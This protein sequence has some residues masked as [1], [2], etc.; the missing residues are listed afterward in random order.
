MWLLGTRTRNKRLKV[1]LFMH[2]Q[3]RSLLMRSPGE[4]ASAQNHIPCQRSQFDAFDPVNSK[5]S[6]HVNLQHESFG[7]LVN[8]CV[9]RLER[10]STENISTEMAT[11]EGGAGEREAPVVFHERSAGSGLNMYT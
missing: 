2:L 5:W 11:K 6:T 1:L 10:A 7:D 3:G 9:F 4:N 8:K